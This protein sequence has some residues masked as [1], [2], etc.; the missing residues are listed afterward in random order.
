MECYYDIVAVDDDALDLEILM[1]ALRNTSYRIKCFEDTDEA[2]SHLISD[3]PR[4]LIVDYQ[5]CTTDGVAFIT[6]LS[7]LMDINAIN[8]C[9]TSGGRVPADVVAQAH[10]L[11]THVLLKD[12]IFAKGYLAKLCAGEIDWTTL[13]FAA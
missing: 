13:E 3:K 5:M 2:L 6:Q 12:E 7:G 9:L 4:F 11:N 1:R 8:I 10:Q